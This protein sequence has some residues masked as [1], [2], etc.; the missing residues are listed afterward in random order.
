[1]IPKRHS[2]CMK[3]VIAGAVGIYFRNTVKFKLS[4][5][6]ILSHQKL[7]EKLDFSRQISQTSLASSFRG[8][9]DKDDDVVRNS[10]HRSDELDRSGP[11]PTRTESLLPPD[12]CSAA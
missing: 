1:M 8:Y 11:A 9:M 6:M 12:R 2:I 4:L 10:N 3:K 7:F 5:K